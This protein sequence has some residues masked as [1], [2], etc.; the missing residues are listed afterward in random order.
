MKWVKC[1]DQGCC[2]K[3]KRNFSDF[4]KSKEGVFQKL[5]ENRK[6]WLVDFFLQNEIL[7]LLSLKMTKGEAIASIS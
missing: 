6:P 5:L 2:A 3:A 4:S 7:K 1:V